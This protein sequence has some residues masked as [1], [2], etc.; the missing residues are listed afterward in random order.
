MKQLKKMWVSFWGKR[1]WIYEDEK[2]L[3]EILIYHHKIYII[4]K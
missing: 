3:C 4:K 2:E 1:Y